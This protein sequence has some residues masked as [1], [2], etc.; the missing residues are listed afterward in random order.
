MS[1]A[2]SSLRIETEELIS[3]L[4][5]RRPE[6]ISKSDLGRYHEAVRFAA[7]GRQMLTYHAGMSRP[8]EKRIAELLG[9]RDVMMA[10]NLAYIAD[11]ERGR[12]KVLVFAHNYHLK[13]GEAAWQFGPQRVTWWPAGA[14]VRA[15]LGSQYAVI[16]M[17]VGKSSAMGIGE[18]ETGSLEAALS[19]GAGT[20]RLIA[21][22]GGKRLS[23]AAIDAI[24]SRT[25]TPQY[26]PFTRESVTD[27]DFLTVIDSVD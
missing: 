4:E 16:G 17:G 1:A 5:V 26:F 22:H 3:E 6:L 20:V 12:G 27:F 9:L 15:M 25:G 13:Y 8:S 2:A 10:D 14:H 11:R 23:Q 18:P 21:T 7:L 19:A 24:T